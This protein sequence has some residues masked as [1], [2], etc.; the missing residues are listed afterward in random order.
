MI[1]IEDIEYKLQLEM[2][3]GPSAPEFAFVN[4][5]VISNIFHEGISA[6]YIPNSHYGFSGFAL[7]VSFGRLELIP[8]SFLSKDEVIFSYSRNIALDILYKLGLE[9][10]KNSVHR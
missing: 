8:C 3:F 5:D 9:Y 6:R 2:Q 1:D 10:G 4:P 7:W